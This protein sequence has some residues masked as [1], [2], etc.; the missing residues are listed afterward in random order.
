MQAVDP[1]F[2]AD[3]AVI[4]GYQLPLAQY[5][6]EA[7]VGVF[8]RRLSTSYQRAGSNR[9][10]HQQRG[11]RIRRFPTICVHRRGRV[12]RKLEVEIRSIHQRLWGLLR[13]FGHPS[14]GGS[15]LHKA[16]HSSSPLVV[17]VSQSMPKMLAQAERNR[18]AHTC[19]QPAEATALGDR[20]RSC[21]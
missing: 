11:R 17:I 6:T 9:C 5:P 2:R 18:Q 3:H 7:S 15:D 4:A 16:R 10:G 12:L 8:N 21:R 1:G 14:A 20:H 19:R 13:R